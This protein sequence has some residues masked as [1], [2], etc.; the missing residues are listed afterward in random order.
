MLCRAAK[1]QFKIEKCVGV[2]LSEDMLRVAEQIE[3]NWNMV[4]I[5]NRKYINILNFLI[6][7]ESIKTEDSTPVEFNRYLTVDP[8]VIIL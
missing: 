5:I 3:G 7:L 1:E 4:C 8:K 2:D 6:I